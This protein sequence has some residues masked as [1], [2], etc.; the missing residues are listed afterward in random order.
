MDPWDLILEK[1]LYRSQCA[2]KVNENLAQEICFLKFS[3]SLQVV[4]SVLSSP[5]VLTSFLNIIPACFRLYDYKIKQSKSIIYRLCN[6][7]LNMACLAVVQ[8]PVKCTSLLFLLE[9]DDITIKFIGS[10]YHHK[11]DS[12]AQN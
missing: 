3:F 1:K 4:N 2:E 12:L 6:W 10:V 5:N 11:F 7:N 9:Y 8:I